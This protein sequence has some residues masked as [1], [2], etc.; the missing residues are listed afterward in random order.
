L[1]GKGDVLNLAIGYYSEFNAENYAVAKLNLKSQLR[2]AKVKVEKLI[3]AERQI[4]N[5]FK[6]FGDPEIEIGEIKDEI[7]ELK[8]QIEVIKEE[9]K[10]ELIEEVNQKD[11]KELE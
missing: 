10:E 5:S 7:E 1:T 8:E 11:I 4:N 2:R 3:R 6:I 9:V